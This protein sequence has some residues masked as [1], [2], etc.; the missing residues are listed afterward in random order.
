MLCIRSVFIVSSAVLALGVA[1]A[2][3][4]PQPDTPPVEAAPP[5]EPAANSATAPQG[6]MTTVS[7]G[8]LKAAFESVGLSVSTKTAPNG[9]SYFEARNGGDLLMGATVLCSGANQTDCKKVVLESGQLNRAISYEELTRFNTSG[10][11]SRVFTYDLKKKQP[12]LGLTV[13]LHGS[14]DAEFL[15]GMVR[16]L[17]SDMQS[18]LG[19]LQGRQITGYSA[20]D[21]AETL[22]PGSFKTVPSGGP[23]TIQAFQVGK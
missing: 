14:V 16:G 10:F 7:M 19:Q 5:N 2:Q 20:A 21:P 12:S 4:V 6:A 11:A 13:D 17:M 3:I 22:V 15:P 1:S 23:A 9:I 8:D 18:F